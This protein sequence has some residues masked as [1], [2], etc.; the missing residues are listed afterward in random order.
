MAPAQNIAAFLFV[1]VLTASLIQVL[2]SVPSHV[3][4]ITQTAETQT[5]ETQTL[6]TNEAT[7]PRGVS[8]DAFSSPVKSAY[9][10]QRYSSQS[11]AAEPNNAVELAWKFFECL[12]VIMF[13][14]SA[15]TAVIRALPD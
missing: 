10:L 13:G 8:Q 3:P 11:R 9:Q 12:F 15:L 2:P 14:A 6:G 5:A 7:A 1:G 4:P